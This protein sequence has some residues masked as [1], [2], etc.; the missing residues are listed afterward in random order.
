MPNLATWFTPSLQ[1]ISRSSGRSSVLAAA[2]RACVKLTD[3]RLG[4]TTDYTPKGKHGLASNICIGIPNDDIGKLWN[5]AE[6]SET[7]ANSTVARELMVPL[8]SAWSDAERAKCVRGLGEM[9][10]ARYGVAV[11]ASIHRASK[12]NNNEHVHI[13]FTTRTVDANGVFGKKTRILDDAK[14]GEVKK[15]REAVCEIVNA[16]AIEQGDDWYVYAGKFADVLDDHIPTTHISIAHGKNQQ[17]LIDANR[18]DVGQARIELERISANVKSNA[19]KLGE[20][21]AQA[22][23][24]ESSQNAT[25]VRDNSFDETVVAPTREQVLERLRGCPEMAEYVDEA[26]TNESLFLALIEE[27]PRI[28]QR[29]KETEEF[30]AKRL[31]RIEMPENAIKAKEQMEKALFSKQTLRQQFVAWEEMQKELAA[32]PP[33]PAYGFFGG[34]KAHSKVELAEHSEKLQSAN[35]GMEECRKKAVVLNKYLKNPERLRLNNV[36]NETFEHNAKVDAQELEYAQ[37]QEREWEL[38]AQ[39][40][41]EREREQAGQFDWS[42]YLAESDR[43][44]AVRRERASA[45]EYSSGGM[46]M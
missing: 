16:Q 21:T 10:R 46:G 37:Q 25:P 3:E 9:L 34:L 31:H 35:D 22:T 14:T 18:E 19:A 6:K 45:T 4:I 44:N 33:T 5:D 28:I 12:D 8:P 2:Y 7:R 17:A 40:Q 30:E 29:R 32:N 26:A 41:R 42:A 27:E 11:L 39:A 36:Y 23:I 13:L 43:E 38:M 24:A 20:L 15:L 1:T